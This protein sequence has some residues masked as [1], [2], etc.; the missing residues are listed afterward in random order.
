MTESPPI[1]AFSAESN[2]D[3][4]VLRLLTAPRSQILEGPV[5][6]GKDFDLYPKN[7]RKL[8]K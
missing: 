5:H 6:P 3:G 8:Y 1:H 4:S 2:L 7:N